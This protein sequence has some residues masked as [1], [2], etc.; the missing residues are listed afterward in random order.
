MRKMVDGGWRMLDVGWVVGSLL[1]KWLTTYILQVTSYSWELETGSQPSQLSDRWTFFWLS[2]DKHFIIVSFGECV[3][4][5]ANNHSL[6]PPP[7]QNGLDMLSLHLSGHWIGR[8][9]EEGKGRTGNYSDSCCCCCCWVRF[10]FWQPRPGMLLTK[11]T[12]IALTF[13]EQQQE[14]TTCV[15]FTSR[16]TSRA[17]NVKT[18]KYVIC[19]CA[20][21]KIA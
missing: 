9:K 4:H 18:I 12:L 2:N 19:K 15:D 16:H 8:G 1:C 13:S 6:H 20:Q 14:E 10:K 21:H 11:L 3:I 17:C 5:H 7:A